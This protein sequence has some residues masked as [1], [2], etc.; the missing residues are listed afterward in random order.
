MWFLVVSFYEQFVFNVAVADEFL[1]QFSYFDSHRV[2]DSF[3]KQWISE[4]GSYAHYC[5]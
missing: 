2:C 4:L 1:P 3:K 5:D